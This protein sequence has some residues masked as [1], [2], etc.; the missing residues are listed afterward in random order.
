VPFNLLRGLAYPVKL[1]SS[2]GF[3][4][5]LL[6]YCS[7]AARETSSRACNPPVVRLRA[8][9]LMRGVT[10][11]ASQLALKNLFSGDW[12]LRYLRRRTTIVGVAKEM[13]DEDLLVP[14]AGKL[15]TKEA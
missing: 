8:S 10:D 15:A 2:T 5:T 11:A 12:E 6:V 9:T 14:N 13:R 1:E 3:G 7:L 4:V